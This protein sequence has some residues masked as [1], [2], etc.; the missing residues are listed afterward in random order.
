MAALLCINFRK[1]QDGWIF[2][3]E[4]KCVPGSIHRT[5]KTPLNW[6]VKYDLPVL[7]P[8]WFS[9]IL[10]VTHL[11]FLCSTFVAL[12]LCQLLFLLFLPFTQIKKIES[13][14]QYLKRPRCDN[15]K[16]SNRSD[17]KRLASVHRNLLV[18]FGL[19]GSVLDPWHF[20]TD[21]DVLNRICL[22]FNVR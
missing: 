2:G 6:K 15:E 9:L 5:N 20:G 18:Q 3:W 11:P 17:P 10:T 12:W 16:V 13:K 22:F 19:I 7:Y 14:Y 4:C 8:Q 21:P 1:L